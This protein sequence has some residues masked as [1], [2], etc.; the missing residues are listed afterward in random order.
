M[1]DKITVFIARA[2]HT[3]EPGA[4]AGID[5]AP[6]AIAVRD[7]MILEVGTIDTLAPWLTRYPHEIDRQFEDKIIMPA[8]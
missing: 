2:I 7:G 3:M 8:Y 4:L 1:S 6:T 5:N